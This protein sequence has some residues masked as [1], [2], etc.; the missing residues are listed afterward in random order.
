MR[1]AAVRSTLHLDTLAETEDRTVGDWFELMRKSWFS[2]KV[3]TESM[4]RGGMNETPAGEA[5]R[6]MEVAGGLF[7]VGMLDM[8]NAPYLACS[9]DAIASL[10]LDFFEDDS[11]DED[12]AV[13]VGGQSH[14]P[15]T[16][17]IKT[18][19]QPTSVGLSLGQLSLELI[20]C[21]M[22]YETFKK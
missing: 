12:Y 9:P 17:E 7:Q 3:S 13:Q 4:M 22:G 8:K 19:V 16:V 10:K 20:C 14:V 11:F 6:R 18:R 5:V 2:S 21:I 1:N 15:A